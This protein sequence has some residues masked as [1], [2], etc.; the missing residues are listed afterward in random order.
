MTARRR[1]LELA[2]LTPGE[3]LLG[4]LNPDLLQ[5]EETREHEGIRSIALE[6]PLI[7]QEEDILTPTLMESFGPP[8]TSGSINPSF[9]LH[10]GNKVWRQVTGDGN[11]CLY[12]LLS[13]KKVDPVKN[14]ITIGAEEVAVELSMPPPSRFNTSSSNI[15]INSSFLSTYFGSLFTPGT[16]SASV[17]TF[18]YNGTISP[19]ALIR[20]IEELTGCEFEF[21]YT[22]DS[23]TNLITRTLHYK[24]RVGSTHT[25]RIRLGHNT[26]NITLEL[27]ESDVAIAAA[28]IGAPSDSKQE[29][30]DNFHAS[31]KAF[32]DLV[33]SPSV[34][35]PLWVTKDESGNEVNGPLSYPPYAKSAGQGYVVSPES[36]SAASYQLVKHKEKSS[37]T[38]PRTVYFES[39]EE[40]EYN[41]YWLCVDKIREKQQPQVQIDANII[42][43]QGIRTG[44][45][46][47]YNCGDTVYLQLPGY[48]EV[49]EARVQKTVK[50][51]RT[52]SK[53][54]ITLGNYK[55][56]FFSEYLKA[57]GLSRPAYSQIN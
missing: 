1:E 25:D 17:T 29:N 18:A 54:K 49:V 4:Y 14:K 32:E 38:T 30:I 6:Y 52:P 55:I 9:L 34:Q 44:T 47:R 28:P 48:Q 23:A 15:T 5:L 42:D 16:I 57:G 51:P 10:S 20:K 53:D 19:M 31:R 2:I 13:N 43:I 21:E 45:P 41:L 3:D 22:Y 40:N 12:V 50:N 8:D 35:I 11:S 56:N 36:E 7:T 27:D 26:E 37:S 39:S 24:D 46:T 33:V